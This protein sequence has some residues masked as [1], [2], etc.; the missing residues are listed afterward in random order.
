M[1]KKVVKKALEPSPAVPNP[2]DVH[3]YAATDPIPVP[4]ALESDTDTTWALWQDLSAEKVQ[5]ARAGDSTFA[6]TV[7]AAL[8]FTVAADTAKR[9]P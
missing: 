6:Q 9:R 4:D 2:A 1:V 7:P 5:K 8:P 3:P